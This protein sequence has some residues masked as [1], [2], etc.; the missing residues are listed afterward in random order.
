LVRSIVTNASGQY[1]FDA[2]PL[3]KYNITVSMQGFKKV[4]S[5]ATNCRSANR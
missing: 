3:G 1:S 2:L 5:S 4:V